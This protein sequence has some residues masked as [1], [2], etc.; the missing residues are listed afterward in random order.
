MF[1]FDFNNAGGVGDDDDN[2]NDDDD[3]GGS[4]I[5]LI[6]DDSIEDI[7]DNCDRFRKK[8]FL[9]FGFNFFV[10]LAYYLVPNWI[11]RVLS[12]GPT[13][14]VNSIECHCPRQRFK[15]RDAG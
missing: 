10:K 14:W 1:H 15:L 4:G 6:Q 12:C 2:D 3:A 8:A 5:K 11:C 7:F 13:G 9:V